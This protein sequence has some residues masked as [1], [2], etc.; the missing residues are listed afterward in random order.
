[1]VTAQARRGDITAL[2][3]T[4]GEIA[5]RKTVNL[6]FKAGGII[7]TIA[8]EG[9]RVEAGDILAELETESLVLQVEQAQSSLETAQGNYRAAQVAYQQALDANHTTIQSADLT[10][11]QA[12]ISVRQ[13]Q[14]ALEDAFRYLDAVKRDPTATRSMKAT[15]I[16]GVHS[17]KRSLETA[18]K[19]QETAYWNSLSQKQA[20]QAQLD[21]AAANLETVQAQLSSAQIALKQAQQTLEEAQIKAS[22][23]GTVLATT[24]EEG[25]YVAPGL[26]L[27]TLADISELKVTGTVDETDIAN[28]KEGQ[29]VDITLDAYPNQT[30]MGELVEI[31]PSAEKGQGVA[32]FKITI[33]ISDSSGIPLKAGLTANIDIIT[34]SKKEVLLV[35]AEAVREKDGKQVVTLIDEKGKTNEVEVVTG[36]T[37]YDN[38]EIITGLKEGDEVVVITGTE[39]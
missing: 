31:A 30:I 5:P 24:L 22:F 9:D 23:D 27:L 33:R 32:T 18:Q 26:S 21:T 37:D 10:Y 13:A 1:M 17:A 8:E 2:V 3:S 7:K 28:L 6:S 25:E 12:E 4:T 14:K 20:A 11:E 35:P 39:E 16:N 19:N 15:A 34:A 29:Q 36:L 38:T